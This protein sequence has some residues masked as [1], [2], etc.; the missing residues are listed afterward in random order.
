MESVS[1]GSPAWPCPEWAWSLKI[2]NG[3]FSLSGWCRFRAHGSLVGSVGFATFPRPG[4]GVAP[5]ARYVAGGQLVWGFG[6][7]LSCIVPLIS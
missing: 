1:L 6:V 7:P 5:S 2:V 4:L 3:M